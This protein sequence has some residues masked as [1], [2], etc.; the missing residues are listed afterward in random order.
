MVIDV[1]ITY[2]EI[3][4]NKR[5]IFGDVNFDEE[6]LEKV[7]KITPVPGGVGPMTITM[8]LN[9]LIVGWMRQNFDLMMN[10]SIYRSI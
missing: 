5:K 6:M 10:E 4:G 3:E 1:G 8:L 9:N 2:K 7:S